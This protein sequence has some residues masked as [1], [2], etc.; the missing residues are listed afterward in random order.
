[1]ATTDTSEKGLEALIVASLTGRSGA[2]AAS[3]GGVRE[4]GTTYASGGYVL[5]DPAD[6]DRAN[7]VD[8]AKLLAFLRATQPRVVEQFGLEEQGTG[9]A[10]FLARLQG[11]VA[12]RG[13]VDVLRKGIKHGPAGVALFY[14]TPTAG[15]ALAAERYAENVFSV[16]R[17]SGTAR[18]RRNWRSI[19]CCSS[20]GC[21]WRRSS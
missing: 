12:K 8:L 19:W 2:G 9:R 16:T 3:L 1:M 18:T 13:V 20:T 4:D 21:R 6:Y 14:G 11:E 7:A 10:N 5:G 17:Q 15:N